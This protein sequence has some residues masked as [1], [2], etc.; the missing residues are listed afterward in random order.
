MPGHSTGLE[1]VARQLDEKPMAV[2]VRKKG[3]RIHSNTI[4]SPKIFMLTCKKSVASVIHRRCENEDGSDVLL[5][6][7]DHLETQSLQSCHVVLNY[8][9]ERDEQLAFWH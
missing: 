9:T 3:L 2:Y 4:L 1:S 6:H 5:C 8:D 7:T